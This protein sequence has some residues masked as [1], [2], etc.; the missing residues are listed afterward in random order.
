MVVE[1][2]HDAAADGG[3]QAVALLRGDRPHRPAL[4][5]QIGGSEPLRV[6]VHREVFGALDGEALLLENGTKLSL[7]VTP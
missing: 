5:D 4:H 3:G 2:V 6:V 1:A 7:I